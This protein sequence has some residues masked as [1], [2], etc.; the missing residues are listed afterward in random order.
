M[1]TDQE[2][3]PLLVQ[4]MA[5]MVQTHAELQEQNYQ[6]LQ[7][8]EESISAAIKQAMKDY[9][10]ATGMHIIDVDVSVYMCMRGAVMDESVLSDVT[11]SSNFPSLG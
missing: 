11:V 6:H 3:A 10:Q 7:R 4:R 5:Q 8:A 9:H 2:N 1:D